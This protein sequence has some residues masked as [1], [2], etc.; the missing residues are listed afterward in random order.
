MNHAYYVSVGVLLR[1]P[2]AGV[3]VGLTVEYIGRGLLYSRRGLS[4]LIV[5]TQCDF[6][7]YNHKHNPAPLSSQEAHPLF[8]SNFAHSIRLVLC[9][10]VGSP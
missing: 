4:N 7:V 8:D 10:D 1:C 6:D 9:G 5:D 3:S 2:R